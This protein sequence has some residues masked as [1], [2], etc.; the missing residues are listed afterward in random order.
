MSPLTA[1]SLLFLL[2]LSADVCAVNPCPQFVFTKAQQTLGDTRSFGLDVG[3]VDGDGDVDIFLPDFRSYSQLWLNNGDR[4]FS[5]SPQSFPTMG[6][7]SLAMGD[8]N[9]DTFLDVFITSQD[10]P[11]RVYFNDG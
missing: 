6:V 8:F 3:D 9:G 1:S 7:H 11:S 5:L 4:T 10:L 2:L